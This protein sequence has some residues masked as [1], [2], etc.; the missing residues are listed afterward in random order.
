MDVFFDFFEGAGLI[1]AIIFGGVLII[2]ILVRLCTGSVKKLAKLIVLLNDNV[3]LV[4]QEVDDIRHDID[5]C[6]PCQ[7][8][9]KSEHSDKYYQD[10]E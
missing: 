4:R 9:T 2:D 1:I 5:E 8:K 7:D 10:A 3:K 6:P